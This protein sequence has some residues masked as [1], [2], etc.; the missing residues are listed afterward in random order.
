MP[1]VPSAPNR[2]SAEEEQPETVSEDEQRRRRMEWLQA[3]A[4]RMQLEEQEASKPSITPAT[5]AHAIT[6]QHS[7]SIDVAS[8]AAIR[9]LAA[10]VKESRVVR[11]YF[12]A[13]NG[14]VPDREVFLNKY[15]PLLRSLCL[16][17]DV[18]LQLTQFSSARQ[19]REDAFGASALEV[20]LSTIDQAD[21]FV[22][23][24][25]REAEDPVPSEQLRE[26]LILHEI[27]NSFF[28]IH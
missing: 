26:V 16:P 1:N 13:T 25:G 15:I 9:S 20:T 10:R 23:I 19:S 12:T 28:L 3:E 2:E 21:V 7:P 6:S 27:S 24:V 22:A 11:L 14:A 8:N 17:A 4:A 5:S 18:Q